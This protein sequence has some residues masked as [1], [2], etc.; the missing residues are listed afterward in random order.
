MDRPYKTPG[1]VKRAREQVQAMLNRDGV[2]TPPQTSDGSPTKAGKNRAAQGLEPKGGQIISRPTQVAQWPLGN[3]G[4]PFPSNDDPNS[5]T[6]TPRPRQAPQ[7]PP[8]PS[9]S[10]IPSMLDQSKP[11]Q[12]TPVFFTPPPNVPEAYQESPRSFNVSSPSDSSARQTVSSI[13]VIPDFPAP[14]PASSGPRK[15]AVLGPPPSSRRGQSSFYSNASFVSPIPEESPRSKS[16]GS[17]ASS[18]AMP[19]SW[20]QESPRPD[21]PGYGD[22]FYD[23]TASEK[24]RGSMSDDYGDESN[25]VRSASLG[26]KGKPAL[27]NT[28]QP[29]QSSSQERSFPTS[30]DTTPDGGPFGSAG[31]SSSETIPTMKLFQQTQRNAANGENVSS[32]RILQAF[33]AASSADP[34]ESVAVADAPHHQSRLSAMRRPPRLDIDAVRAAEARGSL[35][36]LPDLIRR[37]T[38]L[39]SMIDKGNRPASRLDALDEY[40]NE[41]GMSFPRSST[42]LL[43]DQDGSLTCVG[44]DDRHRSGLSDMLAAFPPPVHTPRGNT[45]SPSSWLRNSTWPAAPA[46]DRS[47]SHSRSPSGQIETKP[48]RRCCGLPLW[49]F[50]LLILLLLALIVAAIVVPLEFFVFKNLGNQ[51]KEPSLG[52]CQKDFP[53]LNGGTNVL[54]QNKCSCICINGFTGPTCGDGSATG[55]AT[56]NLVSTDGQSNI[57]N[58]TLGRAIPRLL[59][60]SSKNFSIPL[61][62]TTILARFNSGSLSCIAQNSLVTFDGRSTR[63]GSPSDEVDDMTSKQAVALNQAEVFPLISII[64]ILPI[65]FFTPTTT[66]TVTVP[67]ESPYSMTSVPAKTTSSSTSSLTQVTLPP[68]SPSSSS[69]TTSSTT[70]SSSTTSSSITM[71]T[72]L[73]IDTSTLSAYPMSMMPPM[74]P[75]G[76]PPGTL[77]VVTEEKL[78]F[79]RTAVLF[80]LQEKSV[81]NAISAQSTL[82]RLFSKVTQ[83][84]TQKASQVT[85]AQAF[86]FDLGN[87]NTINLVDLSVN[88]GRGPIG[89][90]RDKT[91]VD[92]A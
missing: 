72:T 82:Q 78:D 84:K 27:I 30:A 64:T 45:A 60:D 25:L 28:R 59:A 81:D 23:E 79:A 90:K 11:Q 50:I 63:S 47:S 19:D 87:G 75:S 2:M 42:S 43:G 31:T 39:A 69:T 4:A 20:P 62:G 51:N 89:R 33:A 68:F 5:F 67:R 16:H 65:I 17:Y 21:S 8:R 58:V 1:S 41:K 13:G 70:T 32:E 36:S 24:S 83:G 40:M 57:Q 71:P 26:K 34:R 80:I 6:P 29:G 66:T 53:C 86:N 14:A 56:T 10:R 88:V 22:A 3:S 35:T 46:G 52:Q 55:C 92:S 44:A 77:F 18:A 9:Q 76:P 15:S 48:K 61:S 38:R 37:A 12:P 85:E 91:S 7:R 74:A 49:A 73:L 54:S